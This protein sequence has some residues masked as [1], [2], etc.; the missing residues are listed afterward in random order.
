[1]LFLDIYGQT[2]LDLSIVGRDTVYIEGKISTRKWEDKEGNARYSTH[3]I[4]DKMTM[5]GA[6][7]GNTPSSM[8]N[9]DTETP[10]QESLEESGNDDLPF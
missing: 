6:K 5:S 4:A 9:Q 3:I 1:M 7:Q 2:N 8:P 10:T